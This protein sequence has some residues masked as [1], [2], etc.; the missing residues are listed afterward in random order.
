M[1]NTCHHIEREPV[2]CL[3]E[4]EQPDTLTAYSKKLSRLGLQ[5]AKF[6]Q[7]VSAMRVRQSQRA[8]VSR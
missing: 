8:G 3:S 5:K 7:S 6:E 2:G 4:D 1:F